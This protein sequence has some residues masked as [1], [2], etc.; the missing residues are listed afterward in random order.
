MEGGAVPGHY[1]KLYFWPRQSIGWIDVA[2]FLFSA[3]Q[4]NDLKP[5]SDCSL[6]S[7]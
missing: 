3:K 5:L 4:N 7:Y 1:M 6:D 2:F